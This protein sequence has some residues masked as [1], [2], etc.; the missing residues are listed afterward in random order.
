MLALRPPLETAERCNNIPVYILRADNKRIP[1]SVTTS[2]LRDER[3]APIG[4]VEVFRDL[5]EIHTLR[6][7][8]SKDPSL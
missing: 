3:G 1:V 2:I 6:Q 8:L 5:S 4:A 7:A